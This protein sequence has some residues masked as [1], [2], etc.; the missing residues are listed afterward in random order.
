MERMFLIEIVDIPTHQ[1]NNSFLQI[2]WMCS[3]VRKKR[4]INPKTQTDE[5]Q[6]PNGKFSFGFVYEP[7]WIWNN[8]NNSNRKKR[9]ILKILQQLYELHKQTWSKS[10]N[11]PISFTVLVIPGSVSRYSPT[12]FCISFKFCCRF[13]VFPLHSVFQLNC[14]GKIIMT[15]RM[16]PIIRSRWWH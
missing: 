14:S 16:N 12:N 9:R 8:S 15:F 13:L 10:R 4:N 5:S 6:A 1:R 7:E 2:H 3:R 11:P